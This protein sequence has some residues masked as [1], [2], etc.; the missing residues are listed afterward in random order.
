MVPENLS[1]QYQSRQSAG[2][3]SDAAMIGEI[4]KIHD[5]FQFELKFSYQLDA[6]KAQTRYNVDTYIFVPN[7]LGINAEHYSKE[8]FY[9]DIQSYFRLKT[10]AVL[11]RNLDGSAASPLQKL[12]NCVER[13]SL[14]A[15]TGNVTDYIYRLKL[16]CSIFRSALR[17]EKQFIAQQHVADDIQCHLRNYLRDS[18][19]AL[20]NFRGLRNAINI[21]IIPSKCFRLYQYA[22]EFLSLIVNENYR[23]LHDFLSA[24]DAVKFAD[25]RGEIITLAQA[26]IAYRKA[27]GY[28][29]IPLE[30][31]RNETM[32]FRRSAL[33]KFVSSVL[34]L[35]ARKDKEGAWLEQLLFG[36]AAAMAMAFATS[37]IFF[38]RSRF[39]ELTFTFFLVLVLSYIFK[40]RIKDSL[41]RYVSMNVRKYFFDHKTTIRNSFE[42]R[43]GFLR[44]KFMF[45]KEDS[46]PAS[47][48]AVRK[49]DFMVGIDDEFFG[50]KIM[51]YRKKITLFSDMFQ[52]LYPD[53]RINAVNDIIRLDVLN[54]TRKMDNPYE[55][56]YIPRADGYHKAKGAKV[57]H[58]NIIL[59][60]NLDGGESIVNHLRLIFNRNGIKR[61]EKIGL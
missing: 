60:Y 13:L 33:K 4:V 51:L 30:D 2:T 25:F 48:R 10:P 26:E 61:I 40:D 49:K 22:C 31:S 21:S 34:F 37:V 15:C 45:I 9:Q 39:E 14:D 17:D 53:T 27:A 58:L 20:T 43:I 12:R 42:Q 11:L 8:C 50:E 56:V 46:V 59:K 7:N 57:Y 35:K 55:D 6:G 3:V 52:T 28:A 1:A 23:E 29:S 24:S 32:I 41:K 54:F 38:S 5:K 36:A 19:L 16:F 47:I 44:E 18:Q